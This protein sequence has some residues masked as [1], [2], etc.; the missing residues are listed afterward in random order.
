LSQPMKEMGADLCA[1][2][3]NYGNNP[4]LKWNL[5]NVS[6]KV[7]E[8]GNIRPIKGQ[9]NRQRIDGAVSLLIAYT[10]LFNNL[11]DYLNII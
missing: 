6:I 5:T 2:K 4:V 7:D 1:K 10:V 8:N 9:S 11:Q 3:I